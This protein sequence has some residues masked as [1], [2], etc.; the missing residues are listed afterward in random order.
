[1]EPK[2]YCLVYTMWT[3]VILNNKKKKTIWNKF[4]RK[5]K[6]SQAAPFTAL[7]NT[8]NYICRRLI[9]NYIHH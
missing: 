4:N 7:R 6:N 8:V 1:M 9:L 2:M 5:H 3:L